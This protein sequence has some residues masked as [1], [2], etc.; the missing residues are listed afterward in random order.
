M[1]V[2][3]L[4]ELSML[5]RL[6]FK[7]IECG[8]RAITPAKEDLADALREIQKG[9]GKSERAGFSTGSIHLPRD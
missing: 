9:V 7:K 1:A 6:I 3:I 8:E 5:S 2:P 4:A